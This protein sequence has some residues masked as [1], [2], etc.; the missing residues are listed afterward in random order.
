MA[1][2][3]RKKSLKPWIFAGA[4]ATGIAVLSYTLWGGEP[5]AL[6]FD[7]DS[8]AFDALTT[9]ETVPVAHVTEEQRQELIARLRAAFT[10]IRYDFDGNGKVDDQDL[11]RLFL[12]KI[13]EERGEKGIPDW[14][15]ALAT[16]S[17]GNLSLTE[18]FKHDGL[19]LVPDPDAKSMA[20]GFGYDT[21]TSLLARERSDLVQAFITGN[22]K[23]ILRELLELLN[24]H[25]HGFI[26]VPPGD[27]NADQL[28]EAYAH[29]FR[30]TRP[31]VDGNAMAQI[32]KNLGFTDFV[33]KVLAGTASPSD[34]AALAL[35]LKEQ[36]LK[37]S[38]LVVETRGINTFFADLH[39][40]GIT[41]LSKPA[42]VRKFLPSVDE[43]PAS[44]LDLWKQSAPAL[45][46]R[47][48]AG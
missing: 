2:R 16:D 31:D 42:E 41:I 27:V 26:A 17:S 23:I 19:V 22:Q 35:P 10:D 4:A 9:G 25:R 7:P 21:D 30:M 18:L 14:L 12:K 13:A 33:K 29:A 40:L 34:Y 11:T 39:N 3:K 38:E 20:F 8:T 24:F 6:F 37:R 32:L 44:T 1:Q 15:K 5:A 45:K 36:I 43:V 28:V 47:I 48:V 46:P